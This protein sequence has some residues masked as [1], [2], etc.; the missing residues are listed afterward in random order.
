M[1][2]QPPKILVSEEKA[3]TTTTTVAGLNEAVF[4]GSASTTHRRLGRLFDVAHNRVSDLIVT[5]ELARN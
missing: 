3:T 5:E 1:A 4:Y 2:E